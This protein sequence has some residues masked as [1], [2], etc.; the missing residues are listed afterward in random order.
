MQRLKVKVELDHPSPKSLS[1]MIGL[2][3]SEFDNSA[4]FINHNAVL[5][6]EVQLNGR[7]Y[8]HRGTRIFCKTP[9][10]ITL[11]NQLI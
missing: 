3:T 9:V 7:Y 4:A 8:P 11:A 10:T 2:I 1:V 5:D 6:F